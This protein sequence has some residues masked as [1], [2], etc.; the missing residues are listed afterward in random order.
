ME[1]S[2]REFLKLSGAGAGGVAVLGLMKPRTGRAEALPGEIPLHKKI[3][4][5]TTICPYCGVGCGF[6]VASENGVLVNLEGDPEHPI[7]QGTAC[8]KGGAQFQLSAH[9]PRRLGKVRYRSPG[10]SQWEEKPWDW[11]IDEIAKRIKNTRDSNWVEKDKDGYVVNRTEAIA[12]LGGA[13]LDN[14]ECY[15]ISKLMRAL[16][17][18]YLEH[19]ARI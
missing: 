4:E 17:L 18:V 3:G 13:A 14:E 12:S 11:A 8:A 16:G 5:T 1:L 6:V 7:N 10:A 9:N 2:R 15:L 19:Q